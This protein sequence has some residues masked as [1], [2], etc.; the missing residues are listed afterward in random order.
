MQT[1]K[2]KQALVEYEYILEH[3]VGNVI[4]LSKT[5]ELYVTLNRRDDAYR[6][7]MHLAELYAQAGQ[8]AR[9]EAAWQKAV[10]LSPVDPEPH[11]RLAV[12]YQ[13]KKDFALMVQERL[14]AAQGYLLR[15]DSVAASAQC[16]EVLRVDA[17][18]AQAQHLL[19]QLRGQGPSSGPLAQAAGAAY[20]PPTGM[21][22]GTTT[23]G[24][25]SGPVAGAGDAADD[26]GSLSNTSGGKTGIM[27][28][29]GNFSGAGNPGSAFAGRGMAR[30]GVGS[31]PRVRKNN[32]RGQGGLRQAQTFQTQGRFSD[33]ID[34]CE[35]NLA[36]GFDR[37]EALYF[38]G[39]LYQEQRR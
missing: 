6:A 2:W 16:K 27:G 18:N 23:G 39:W 35:Q 36:N 14:A 19:S 8:G 10:Q 12:Y 37:P 38:L 24:L 4:A 26:K 22:A 31:A 32:S 25:P 17:S 21:T 1:K 9:A 7:Y 11:E 28:N 33:A 5:A 34:L 15:N 30:G 3:D 20:T 13:G 29:M